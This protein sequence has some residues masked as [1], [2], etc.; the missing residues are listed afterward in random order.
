MNI[1]VLLGSPNRQ[2]SSR[3]LAESFRQGAEEAGHTVE[4]IDVAHGNIH[5]CTG[6]IHCGYEG[7]CVQKD[8]VETIRRKI[9][10]GHDGICD[11]S[12]LPLAGPLHWI[13]TVR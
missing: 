1:V 13:Q 11:P 5:P 8:D 7:P 6:C 12:L 2:G 4:M 3:M 9:P 10:G